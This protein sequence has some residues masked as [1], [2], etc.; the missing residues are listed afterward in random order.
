MTKETHKHP[1][2]HGF[3]ARFFFGKKDAPKAPLPGYIEEMYH[4]H[5]SDSRKDLGE[6]I[7]RRSMDERRMSTEE[8]PRTSEA[9]DA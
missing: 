3:F 6:F 2:T 1:H 8:T 7:R 9:D 5:T 4:G